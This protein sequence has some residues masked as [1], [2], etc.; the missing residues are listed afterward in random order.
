MHFTHFIEVYNE[1]HD[2]RLWLLGTTLLPLTR[3]QKSVE[4]GEESSRTKS[5]LVDSLVP[6]QGILYVYYTLYKTD[7][8]TDRQRQTYRQSE[9][10]RPIDRQSCK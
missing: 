3:A 9:R 6:K 10:Q 8:P 7:K 2:P 1:N 5:N 4:D